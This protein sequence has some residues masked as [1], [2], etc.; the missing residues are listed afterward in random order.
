MRRALSL[1]A[2]LV[3]PVAVFASAGE[4]FLLLLAAIAAAAAL[5][6]PAVRAAATK[7]LWL[8]ILYATAI[9]GAISAFWA[10]SAADALRLAPSLLIL[11]AAAAVPFA[12]AGKMDE[13]GREWFL[14]WAW[15]GFAVGGALL[16][17]EL[18]A[19]FPILRAV[20]GL[21]RTGPG[22]P[23]VGLLGPALAVLAL[24]L[25]PLVA[26]AWNTARGNAV[27]AVLAAAVLVAVGGNLAA[28]VALAAGAIAFAA[29]RFGGPVVV[30][31]LTGIA[32]AATATAPLL[33]TLPNPDELA[34]NFSED[35]RSAL[36][37]L[38]IWE[39]TAERAGER[40]FLGW[41]L[42][43]S[44]SIPGAEELV[45]PSGPQLSLHPHN[46]ALQ[47]WLELGAFGA[48]ALAMFIWFTGRGVAAI[49]DP[50]ARAGAA[51]AF[52]G[53]LCLAFLSFGIWQNWWI[54]T[55]AL[56]AAFAR[57]AIP[58]NGPTP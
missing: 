22:S 28:G 8:R 38:Y 18:L 23:H 46:A 20:R 17:V 1:A 27:P 6:L 7:P 58:K 30:L 33:A 47:V 24:M 25:W 21:P 50:L 12:L 55:L 32:A 34:A 13:A 10:V 5:G 56:T 40:P 51:G 26:S 14:R 45:L 57:A 54:A 15:V 35:N 43:S 2:I 48:M 42:D 41:G 3:L 44:R 9:W 16:A 19:E 53:A 37:R 31:V 11:F 4:T 36:H 29:V 52:A 39:F 49:S